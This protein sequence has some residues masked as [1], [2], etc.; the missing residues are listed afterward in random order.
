[1][2]SATP[3]PV[4]TIIAVGVARPN[5]HGHEI[6][7][8]EIAIDRE[9]SSPFPIE[10]HTAKVTMPIP[11]TVG[12]NI[13]LTLSAIFSIGA[14]EDV[15][16]S[17][18]FIIF[19]NAVSLPTFSILTV[20]APD[21]FMLPPIT[22][23]PLNFSTGTDSPVIKDSST[24]PN[25]ST[26]TPSDAIDSP[27]L[28]KIKSPTL[29]FSIGMSTWILDGSNLLFSPTFLAVLGVKSISFRMLEDVF[30]LALA[31]KNLPRVISVKIMPADSKYRSIAKRW[32]ACISSFFIAIKIFTIAYIPYT[33]EAPEPIAIRESIF[34]FLLNKFLIPFIKNLLLT[35]TT[36]INN[37]I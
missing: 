10:S 1:M 4:P 36:G 14:L 16:S 6:T 21:L 37:A 29:S 5:A 15:A 26:T 2:P 13:L 8:T 31:S 23:L 24:L 25:P 17:T 35:N 9:N 22:L 30:L 27:A 33:M 11:I 12:T 18:S 28:T 20:K 34:G 3:L 19:D 32:T 7:K